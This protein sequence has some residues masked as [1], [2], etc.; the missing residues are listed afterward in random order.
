MARCKICKANIPDG[1]EYCT[2]CQ[3]KS[4]M[5]VDESYLD[6]LLNSVK[7]TA[8]VTE[9]IYK[10]K[11][12]T[13]TNT[14]N[15]QDLSASSKQKMGANSNHDMS[16][17]DTAFTEIVEPDTQ[18]FM[19]YQVDLS[20]L[21][22]FSQYYMEDDLN[23]LQ[24]DIVI[25]DEELFGVDLSELISDHRQSEKV[26]EAEVISQAT[27]QL[28]KDEFLEEEI[29]DGLI[30]DEQIPE[31][32]IPEGQIPE[33]QLPK[34]RI[35]EEELLKEKSQ[36]EELP[37]EAFQE[38]IAED[39]D[40]RDVILSDNT[41]EEDITSVQ[42]DNHYNSE[43][44]PKM[45]VEED[46][47]P[48]LNELLNS[49]NVIPEDYQED[50]VQKEKDAITEEKKES[51]KDEFEQVEPEEDDFLSLL[52]QI[53]SDDPVSDDVKAIND[54]LQG[55][56][57]EEPKKSGTP[58]NVG[59]VFSDALKG[60]TSLNDSDINEEE[61]LNKINVGKE[62][63]GKAK[64]KKELSKKTSKEGKSAKEEKPKK[65][66]FKLLFGNVEEKSTSKKG[67]AS[68][69][70]KEESTVAKETPIKESAKK[71]KVKKPKK[72]APANAGEEEASAEG[73]KGNEKAPTKDTKK[74]KKE[75]KKKTKEIIQV[76]DEIEE[77][78]GRINR[79]GATIV[80]VFFGLLVVLIL[81]GTNMV[82]YTISIENAT[83]YF[84]KQKYTA[85]YNEVYG[86]EIKD[87][88]IEIYDKIMT[89]M[90]VNKQLNS[91]NNY[92]ALGE[93]PQALDSLLK[94]LER[95]DKYIELATMLGIDSDLNYVRNQILAELD[96]EFKL[97]EKNAMKIISYNDRKEYSLAVY[98]VAMENTSN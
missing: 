29:P 42:K 39:I 69:K 75:K 74:E 90:F 79:L 30:S 16:S 40:S 46:F 5:I 9:S 94:G 36:G 28:Q 7:N 56:P 64:Q 71:Q 96:N 87:E 61:I 85:A 67:L 11:N 34:E 63:K 92:Y 82:S 31:G 77:D 33:K 1:T 57:V 53:A 98:D 6:S 19:S 88:D 73:G 59:E 54:L 17:T 68:A 26:P 89:V 15:N 18:D 35:L 27:G 3:D 45:E 13:S 25:G 14:N 91:Y 83:N 43:E 41:P 32:Q 95:Y 2:N 44:P 65:G 76:I 21:E 55:K 10:K 50:L 24:D 58:S 4:E 80:F 62:K 8:P 60:I 37:E 93:Y 84:D 51:N 86:I 97:T 12:G 72:G 48:D 70:D 47:D 49:L 66:F 52:N 20:D 81:V 22:D 23:D 78:E 38:E